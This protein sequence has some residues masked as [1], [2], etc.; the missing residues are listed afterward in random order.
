MAEESLRNAE[1]KYRS[2]FEGGVEGI[3][4]TSVEGQSLTANP[5]MVKMLGYDSEDE[6][7]SIHH[8]L[9][10]SAMGRSE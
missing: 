9:G 2:I 10:E 6:V 5:A 3:Y 7:R 4:E 1:A 8:R